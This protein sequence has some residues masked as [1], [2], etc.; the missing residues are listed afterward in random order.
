[1]SCAPTFWRGAGDAMKM[2]VLGLTGSVAMGKTEAAKA[3]ADLGH[4]VFNADTEVR[5]LLTDDR[6]VIRTV[7]KE[8]PDV[9]TDG[10]VD[11]AKLSEIV[12]AHPR[13]LKAL[14]AILHPHVR[15]AE[16][17][18]IRAARKNGALIAVMEIPLLFETHADEVCD[19]VAVVTAPASVQRRRA[20]DRPG[21]TVAKLRAMLKR[22]MSDR[23][24]R[25]LADFVID[26]GQGKHHMLAQ[27]REIADILCERTPPKDSPG[28][29]ARG[30]SR[31]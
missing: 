21:M 14:E 13:L 4:P 5:Q 1:M 24:K 23:D 15:A 30:R 26:T 2:K 22:Q 8:I 17:L 12:F 18:F 19:A 9:V 25:K 7:R 29:D 28:T 27:V 31:H 3:F 10:V 11:R 20:L 6:R 16:G